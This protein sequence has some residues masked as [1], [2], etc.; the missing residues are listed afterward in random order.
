MPKGKIRPDV[1]LVRVIANRRIGAKLGAMGK[2]TDSTRAHAEEVWAW[3]R[4]HALLK[5]EYQYDRTVPLM[6]EVEVESS[7]DMALVHLLGQHFEIC[8]TCWTNGGVPAQVPAQV[9]TRAILRKPAGDLLR[10]VIA[11]CE[12]AEAAGHKVGN[13]KRKRAHGPLA[14]VEV[15]TGKR[16]TWRERMLAK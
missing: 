4:T 13:T 6:A 12:A 11:D 7:V 2:M 1:P 8:G 9:I 16:D 10:P 15:G 14:V 5:V 3:A